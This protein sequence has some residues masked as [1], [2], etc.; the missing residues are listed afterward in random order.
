M[1]IPQLLETSIENQI[2]NI[3]I[4]EL[5]KHAQNLSDKYM[6][7]E[8]TGK[9]LLSEE[10]E[11]ISYSIMRMPGTFG[12]ITTALKHS[13]K[14][15]PNTKIDS[16]LDIGAGTGAATWALNEY[17]SPS[18]ITC[19]ER[20]QAMRT[21]GARL[22]EYNNE[23]KNVEWINSDITNCDFPKEVDLIIVSYMINELKQEERKKL[24][25]K[26]LKIKSKLILI[27]EPGTP[28]GFKNIKNIQEQII[29]K[30]KHILA[31]CTAQSVCNL[32]EDDWC[33]TT[34]RIERTKL[35]KMLKDGDAPYED[36]KFSYIAITEE[37]FQTENSRI[38]RHP[39]IEKGKITLKLCTKGNI[40][41]K[42]ITKKDGEVFK[43][44]KK[45]KCGDE[46]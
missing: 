17:L 6:K 11:A 5:K 31:P 29:E 37:T 30:G 36:E 13:L 22:L 23:I 38:L 19:I 16:V 45:K 44:A 42:I 12:A 26:L 34:V 43:Q 8:R 27:I 25:E 35:H 14:L 21:V 33:H 46:L 24:I 7:E 20:E 40:E 9:S 15:M 2:K 18:K 1:Q 3:K 10:I 39:I 4:S 28:E 41:Q 32:P